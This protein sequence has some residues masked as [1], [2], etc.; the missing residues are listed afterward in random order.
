MV[1]PFIKTRMRRAFSMA[2]CCRLKPFSLAGPQ[3]HRGVKRSWLRSTNMREWRRRRRKASKSQFASP[4]AQS[5]TGGWA[6]SCAHKLII[7]PNKFGADA[8]FSCD[9]ILLPHNGSDHGTGYRR[10]MNFDVTILFP[11]AFLAWL[12]V[13]TL[14]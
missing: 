9:R 2:R 1:Q 10:Y 8:V 13:T 12:V 5:L 3:Y 14:W 11:T 4:K 6:F 7:L